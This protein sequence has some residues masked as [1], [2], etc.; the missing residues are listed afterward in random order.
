M[1]LITPVEPCF[2]SMHLKSYIFALP[3]EKTAWYINK[4]CIGRFYFPF[5][6]YNHNFK[7][8]CSI[9]ATLLIIITDEFDACTCLHVSAFVV[10]S[11]FDLTQGQ[12]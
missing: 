3:E 7:T 8:L 9:H 4:I 6:I 11:D 12:F 10:F 2:K 5:E 1:H